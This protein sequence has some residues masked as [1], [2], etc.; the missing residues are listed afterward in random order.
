MIFN[1]KYT[2]KEISRILSA[3]AFGNLD[4]DLWGINEIHRVSRGDIAFVDHPKYYVKA[5]SS[6]ASLI[7]INQK[8][9]IPEGKAIILTEEPFT[10]FNQLLKYFSPYQ[11]FPEDRAEN[12]RIGKGTKIHPSAAIGK[13][14]TIGRHCLIMPH[15]CIY[16]K[17][18]IGNHVIIHAGTIIGADG[19]YFKNR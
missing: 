18:H 3:P 17:T 5:L 11:F 12:T 16:D 6:E 1:R 7:L 14:A 13:N 4:A 2:V 9:N 19:F 10:K 15:V 8:V